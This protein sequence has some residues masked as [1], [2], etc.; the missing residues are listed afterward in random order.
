MNWEQICNLEK[1]E[2]EL[3]YRNFYDT[4]TYSLDEFAPYRKVTK[5]EYKLML[6]PWISKESL[7]KCKNRDSILKCILNSFFLLPPS[8]S[9]IEKIINDLDIKKCTGPNSIPIFILK[10]FKPFFSLWLSKI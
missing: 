2:S 4:F 5:K 7:H 9:E 8:P 3:S 1:K 6:K 10:L